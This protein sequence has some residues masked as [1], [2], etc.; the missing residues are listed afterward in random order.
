MQ[1]KRIQTF[2][3][4]LLTLIQITSN[5]FA[6]PFQFFN[7]S[8]FTIF[9]GTQFVYLFPSWHWIKYLRNNT[10]IIPEIIV[11]AKQQREIRLQQKAIKWNSIW[12]PLPAYRD[13]MLFVYVCLSHTYDAP[14]L[15]ILVVACQCN[16][17]ESG[18][19][20]TK[21]NNAVGEICLE[22]QKTVQRQKQQQ[23]NNIQTMQ[24]SSM[25]RWYAIAIPIIWKKHIMAE[26]IERKLLVT[27]QYVGRQPLCIWIFI[28]WA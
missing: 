18:F 7:L 17:N 21:T 22:R 20:N 24:Y 15:H 25:V 14:I 6:I 5:T 11:D 28:L 2:I 27:T 10:E 16:N 19:I 13:E 1:S 12:L 3:F 8:Y 26:E 4:L 9:G 23:L